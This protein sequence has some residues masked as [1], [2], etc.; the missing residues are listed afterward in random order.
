LFGTAEERPAGAAVRD[1]GNLTPGPAREGR[2]PLAEGLYDQ[3]S[4]QTPES[5]AESL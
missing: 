5:V 2:D 4:Q 3:G 1:E